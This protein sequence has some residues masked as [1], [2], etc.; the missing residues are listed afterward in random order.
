[1]I[2][3]RQVTAP[4]A[5]LAEVVM[6]SWF[7]WLAKDVQVFA[8]GFR[9]HGTAWGEQDELDPCVIHL[10]VSKGGIYNVLVVA[11]RADVCATSMCPQETEY[12]PA[13]ELPGEAPFPT[14]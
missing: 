1:L 7:A 10:N 4:K 9:H 5:G 6:P 14:P 13:V 3:K 11:D 12:I 2:Y 8:N